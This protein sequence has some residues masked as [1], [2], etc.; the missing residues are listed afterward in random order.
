[1]HVVSFCMHMGICVHVGR[2]LTSINKYLSPVISILNLLLIVTKCCRPAVY[3][4]LAAIKIS[5]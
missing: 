3:H 5:L 2:L 1:M 4:M